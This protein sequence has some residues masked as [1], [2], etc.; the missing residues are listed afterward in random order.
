MLTLIAQAL[1]PVLLI[2]F[3]PVPDTHHTEIKT[4]HKVPVRAYLPIDDDADAH[5]VPGA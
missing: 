3:N 5:A 1:T 2:D 4:A